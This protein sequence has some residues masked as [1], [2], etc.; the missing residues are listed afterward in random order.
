[1]PDT[2][3]V[4]RDYYAGFNQRRLDD[5]AELFA[6]DAELQHRPDG[7][8]LRGPAGYLE[9]ARATLAIFPDLVQDVVQIER[10]GVMVKSESGWYFDAL[11]P[12]FDSVEPVKSQA[13]AISQPASKVPGLLASVGTTSPTGNERALTGI[14]KAGATDSC[15]AVGGNDGKCYGL[16]SDPAQAK[17]IFDVC[18]DGDQCTIT[19]QFDEKAESLGAFSKVEKA[20]S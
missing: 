4:I 8:S 12:G 15:L 9:S 20:P 17:R 10:R 19:G 1:M 14:I 3:R 18:K 13:R 16:P 7:S 6:E 11:A 5:V 2:E